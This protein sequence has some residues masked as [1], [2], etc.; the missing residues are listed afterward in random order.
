MASVFLKCRSNISHETYLAEMPA[1]WRLC[2]PEDGEE[3]EISRD[4]FEAT[5]KKEVCPMLIDGERCMLFEAV[6]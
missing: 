3:S 2:P 6:H 1:G 5:P 4:E